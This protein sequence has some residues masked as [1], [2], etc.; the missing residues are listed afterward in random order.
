MRSTLKSEGVRCI[1]LKL[2]LSGFCQ[3]D[4]KLMYS[5]MKAEFHMLLWG[6]AGRKCGLS[7]PAN[8]RTAGTS[9]LFLIKVLIAKTLARNG[10]N[11]VAGN[12]FLIFL[13]K[14]NPEH[15]S[16]WC[17]QHAREIM[18][19]SKYD[20]HG[21]VHYNTILTKMTNK[22]QLCRIIYYSIV[23][24]LLYM[25]WKIIAHHQNWDWLV[26]SYSATTAA[27]SNTCEWNQ[28]L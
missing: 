17:K 18:K 19:S 4:S 25:F 21:S 12:C 28:K 23:P 3:R 7:L 14:F 8:T 5:F 15:H 24:W 11:F 22:M 2:Y 20:I 16:R 27:D 10:L 1:K 13:E 9:E 26:S 6:P